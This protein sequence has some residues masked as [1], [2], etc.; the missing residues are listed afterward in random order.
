MLTRDGEKQQPYECTRSIFGQCRIAFRSQ[1]VLRVLLEIWRRSIP[2]LSV[3]GQVEHGEAGRVDIM[4]YH[5][6]PKGQYLY[7][8]SEARKNYRGIMRDPDHINFITI[9][10]EP[11]SHFLRYLLVPNTKDHSN[12]NPR[13]IPKGIY[14][15][16]FI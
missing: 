10:R 8:W 2:V 4:H 11:R 3:D 14:I 9:M 6:T 15:Y 13:Y 7:P 1:R 12:Q 16:V 5:I